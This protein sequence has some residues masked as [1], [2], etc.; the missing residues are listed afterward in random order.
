[1]NLHENKS[2]LN[3]YISLT[4]QKESLPRDV[5]EKDY[6]VTLVLKMIYQVD[7]DIVFIGGTSL[8]KCFNIINRFSEDVDLVSKITS[9]KGSQKHTKKIIEFLKNNWTWS[10][11]ENNKEFSDFKTMYLNYENE[12]QSALENRIKIELITFMDPFPIILIDIEPYILKYMTDEDKETYGVIKFKINTQEPFRTLF[13]KIILQK[14]LYDSFLNNN[15][16]ADD[17]IKRARDYYDIHKLWQYYNNKFPFDDE[18]FITM[19]GSRKSNRRGRTSIYLEN[20]NNN[21]LIDMYRKRNIR[22]QLEKIDKR[23]LSI[24]DL[25][26]DDIEKSLKE[27]DDN[28]KRY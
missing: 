27:I 8:S 18:M 7:N 4:A 13:E 22:K 10:Y 3:R 5:V 6:Y 21:S 25:N 1:M 17:Q 15:E 9:R 14:E 23:K 26:C 2:L 11:E 16:E 20:L 28:L 19:L 12:E 24:Q